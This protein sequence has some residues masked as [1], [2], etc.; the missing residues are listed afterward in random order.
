MCLAVPARIAFID[1]P[2]AKYAYAEMNG[3]RQKINIQL[4]DSPEIGDHV[5]I[6]AGFAIEKI[7]E[8]HFDFLNNFFYENN[9]ANQ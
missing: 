3:I 7:E 2:D 9:D 8:E 4:I 6:H 1:G 5:L